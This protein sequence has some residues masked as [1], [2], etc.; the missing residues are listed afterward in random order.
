VQ[1]A[2]RGVLVPAHLAGAASDQPA[3]APAAE[4]AEAVAER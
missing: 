4:P 3:S 2:L 1:P